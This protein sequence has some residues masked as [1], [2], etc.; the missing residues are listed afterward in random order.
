[1][2]V[3]TKDTLFYGQLHA[4]L[5]YSLMK[6]PAVSGAKW[7]I[8]LCGA[9]KSEERRQMELSK[10][11]AYQK[12]ESAKASGNVNQ[13]SSDIGTPTPGRQQFKMPQARGE[14]EMSSGKCYKCLQFGHI[15]KA[16]P[17]KRT[18][19]STRRIATITDDSGNQDSDPWIQTLLGG[20]NGVDKKSNQRRGPVYK[21]N[22]E[23]EGARIRAL[24]C[25]SVTTAV[26]NVTHDQGK[27]TVVNR[28]VPLQEFGTRPTASWC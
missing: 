7:Y 11:Q 25:S 6:I 17:K 5:R 24:L 4:G 21:V 2:S 15:A 20:S 27:E 18:S 10:R 14:L 13:K 16:C 8:E 1:M 19:G 22:V 12:D 28:T 23:I 3:E 9:A 26:T